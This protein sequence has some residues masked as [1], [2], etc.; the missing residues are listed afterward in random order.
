MH[1]T[2]ESEKQAWCERSIKC[3]LKAFSKMTAHKYHLVDKTNAVSR[4]C[5]SYL[6]S[7]DGDSE[8]INIGRMLE[9]FSPK[10]PDHN[11]MSDEA[12]EKTPTP[13]A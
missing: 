11:A 4:H 9:M 2:R 10:T 12:D 5:N 3:L 8:D 6:T 7:T 1:L 13:P